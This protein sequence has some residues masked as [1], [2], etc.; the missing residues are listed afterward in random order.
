MPNPIGSAEK[1]FD[2][3]EIAARFEYDA[4]TGRLTWADGPRMGSPAGHKTSLGYVYIRIGDGT[5]RGTMIAAHRIVWAMHKGTWP[6]SELDHIN[7]NPSDNRIENLREATRLLQA[8]NTNAAGVCFCSQ[9]GKWKATLTVSGRQ[10]W[11]G[12]HPTKAAALEARRAG[13]A[14]YW[15]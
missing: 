10:V 1:R 12:R 3:N 15:A 14:K 6:S 8:R 5:H 13:I 11:L 7:R 4:S 2:P 9:T